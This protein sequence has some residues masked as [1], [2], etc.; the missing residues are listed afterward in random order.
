MKKQGVFLFFWSAEFPE[1]HG[2]HGFTRMWWRE[3]SAGRCFRTGNCSER[4]EDEDENE[5]EETRTR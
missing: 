5:E 1:L 4:S 2:F 3:I